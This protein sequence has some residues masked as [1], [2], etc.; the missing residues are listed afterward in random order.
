MRRRSFNSETTWTKEQ[1]DAK[2]H[3]GWRWYGRN[4]ANYIAMHPKAAGATTLTQARKLAF[5][6]KKGNTR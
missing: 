5:G 2:Y 3:P 6:H 1:L 4:L